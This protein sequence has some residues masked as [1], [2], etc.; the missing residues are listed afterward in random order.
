VNPRNTALLLLV[1][2][3]LG[4]F[5]YFYEVRGGEKRK[6]AEAAAKRLFP[7]ITEDAISAVELTTS[8]GAAAR[9]ERVEGAWRLL[10]PLEFPAD[11]QVAESLV[12]A[13]ANLASETKL[14]SPQGEGVYGLGE[15]ARR[16]RFRAG[17]ADHELLV[18]KATPVGSNTYA[19]TGASGDIYTVATFR[20]TSLARSL[21]DLRDKRVVSFDRD[22]IDRLAVRWEGGGVVLEK[23][24]SGWSLVE[25]LRGPADT[26]TLET[27]L[28]D[29]AFLRADGFEDQPKS[30]HDEGLDRPALRVE[31]RARPEKPSEPFDGGAGETQ[32]KENAA[33]P[34]SFEILVGREVDGTHRVVRGAEAALYRVPKARFD[35]IPRDT[36][37]YRFK[38]LA[39]FV[40]SDAHS[41]E[42]VF[43]AEEGGASQVTQVRAERG[44]AGWSASPE[45]MDAAKA[46]RLVAELSRLKGK[47][48]V[49]D[50][51]GPE[52]LA[53]LGLA[54]P[55]VSLIVRGAK[56]EGGGEA[57]VLA[58]VLLGEDDLVKGIAA[59]AA[60]RPGV[61]RIPHELAEH[62]PV[63]IEAF[64][65]RFAP[66]PSAEPAQPPDS[67][68]PEIEGEPPTGAGTAGEE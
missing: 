27:L 41:F 63:S 48:I 16:V 5:V 59:K 64:R 35:K 40:S 8:D 14:E 53:S 62:F 47:D 11:P 10:A 42:I 4:A 34:R 19:K 20:T 28:S 6:E 24:E 1:A 18:G 60:D 36:T 61:Y 17:E 9:L 22:S 31:L 21:L 25:P 65:N 26:G 54:P 30:D 15:G 32:E 13:L 2:A 58:Q 23:G 12:S 46:A 45:P 3:A 37:A 68:P 67:A 57:P 33:P 50:E 43:H 56:P 51:M 55:R 39:N 7:G 38:E 52:E 29:L 66:E 44:D 49:A